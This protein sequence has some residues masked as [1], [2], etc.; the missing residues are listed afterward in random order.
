MKR[1][2]VS[3]LS[4]LLCLALLLCGC[5][6][7]GEGEP[8]PSPTESGGETQTGQQLSLPVDGDASLHPALT[9]SSTNLILAPLL[10][11]GLFELDGAF[12]P[13]MV[14]CRSYTRSEDGM[15]W[16]FTLRSGVT[17][18]DG[19]P[20]TASD[21]AAALNTARSE[22]SCYQKRLA[23]I[24]SVTA[25]GDYTVLVTLSAP[26]GN[27]PALLDVPLAK[28][29][30]DRPAGTGPYRLTEG[31][32][33]AVLTLRS[34][35]WQA[36]EKALAADTIALQDI[37]AAEDLLYAFDTR[38]IDLVVTDFTGSDSLGFSSDYAV[39]EY[40]T[41][42][43]IYLGFRTTGS[44]PCA[45]PALRA[46][47]SGA[48]DR[49]EI[50]GSVFVHH[51][52]ASAL[53]VNP[54]SSLYDD[55]LGSLEGDGGEALSAL[56]DSVR[57]TLKLVVC[58]ENTF[59][60]SAADRIAASLESCGLSVTVDKLSYED[61]TAAL[62]AGN[63]DLYLAEVTMTGDFNPTALVGTGGSLNFGG[64]TDV[65]TDNLLAAFRSSDETS[66]AAAASALYQD[67]ITKAPI[68]PLCFK[69]GSVLTQWD[70]LG[71]LAPTA[72]NVFRGMEQWTFS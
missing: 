55:T 63:F 17:W 29:G 66:R 8:S 24:T 32:A 30:G 2:T 15:S 22:G 6:G 27:L 28:D 13:Q 38:E 36:G 5:T 4:A 23:G 62:T 25:E 61:Y 35:W 20:L 50:A 43:L 1:G 69:T 26:N 72:S 52:K 45:D 56:S 51:A 70:R 58:N 34:D 7:Q 19:T 65:T 18:S 41:P 42:R 12:T 54:A 49:T 59:K 10:Y 44:S 31:G 40:D 64:Y 16:S 21:A 9:D 57:H 37:G 39:W 67:L 71:G 60:V 11:E 47:I 33:G 53:P 68:A 3:L 48:I 46:A 14:L